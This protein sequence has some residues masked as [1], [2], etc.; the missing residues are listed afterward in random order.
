MVTDYIP[1]SLITT[2]KY[3]NAQPAPKEAGKMNED[4]V[5][6]WDYDT[7]TRL[8]AKSP[9]ENTKCLSCKHLPICLA[10]CIQNSSGSSE[11]PDKC[12]LDYSE[13]SVE[14]FIKALVLTKKTV[15]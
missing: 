3:I 2:E 13:I 4:G 5:I 9:F 1:Q 12:A 11:E 8:Y 6:I 7:L 15:E 14:E 10:T